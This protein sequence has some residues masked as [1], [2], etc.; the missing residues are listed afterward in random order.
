MDHSL[1]CLRSLV[2]PVTDYEMAEQ[3][4]IEIGEI[5]RRYT[6]SYILVL[7]GETIALTCLASATMRWVAGLLVPIAANALE[8]VGGRERG[9]W[10]VSRYA[11][12]PMDGQVHD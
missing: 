10:G 11:N 7:V 9:G 2:P 6:R 8:G 5:D 3:K 4:G 1:G 12:K